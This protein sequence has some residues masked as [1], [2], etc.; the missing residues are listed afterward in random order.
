MPT[1][2]LAGA[3]D[4][5]AIRQAED[6]IAGS[7]ALFDHTVAVGVLLRPAGTLI[8]R[9]LGFALVALAAQPFDQRVGIGWASSSMRGGGGSAGG[10]GLGVLRLGGG[11]AG[12]PLFG[13]AGGD[14]LLRAVSG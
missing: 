4:A 14:L 13:R 1:L 12:P 6:P 8:R 10:F 9:L 2:D 7:E 11:V 5:I 3:H